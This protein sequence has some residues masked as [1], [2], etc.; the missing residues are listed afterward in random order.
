MLKPELHGTVVLDLAR[1][2]F[3]D[4]DGLGLLIRSFKRLRRQE[5]ALVLRNPRPEIMRTLEITGIAQ[6]PGLTI[7]RRSCSTR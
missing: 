3:I 5:G 7:E 4:D 6:I 2:E 1:L